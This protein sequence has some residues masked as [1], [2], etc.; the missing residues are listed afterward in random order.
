MVPLF[1]DAILP[2]I[3]EMWISK[4]E[5]SPLYEILIHRLVSDVHNEK[6][7]RI[8]PTPQNVR[9]TPTYFDDLTNFLNEYWSN[10]GIGF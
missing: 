10:C 7:T 3:S 8:R 5:L 2:H 1:M 6:I 9:P 4:Y